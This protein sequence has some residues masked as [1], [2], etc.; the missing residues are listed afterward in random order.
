MNDQ[1]LG[2]APLDAALARLV[3][4]LRLLLHAAR[5]E[6]RTPRNALELGNLRTQFRHR[7]LQLG[8]LRQQAFGQRFKVATRQLGKRDF[9]WN[10]HARNKSG[11]QRADATSLNLIPA[12]LFAPSTDKRLN[13]TSLA[14]HRQQSKP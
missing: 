11:P 8:V 5:P 13:A 4:R 14:L 12:R 6:H 1:S 2:L 7:L 3:R 9:L 10:R